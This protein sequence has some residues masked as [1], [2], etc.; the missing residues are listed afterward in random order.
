MSNIIND[1]SA[2][3]V[4]GLPTFYNISSSGIFVGGYS[5]SIYA[6]SGFPAY[7]PP[8]TAV[9]SY[10]DLQSNT[11]I[12]EQFPIGG[13]FGPSTIGITTGSLVNGDAIGQVTVTVV[14]IDFFPG[15]SPKKLPI[16][17]GEFLARFGAVNVGIDGISGVPNFEVSL[18]GS[19]ITN[20]DPNANYEPGF[21][22]GLGINPSTLPPHIVPQYD[23]NGALI[24][25]DYAS[26]FAAGT[27]IEMWDGSTKPIEEVN[28][29]D[30]VLSFD[31]TTGNTCAGRVV[32]TQ[33][34]DV[35]VVLDFFGTIVTPGHVYYCSGGR[36]AGKFVPL[37]D[38]LRDDGAIQTS[39]GEDVRATTGAVVGSP[40]D[41]MIQVVTGPVQ[42]DGTVCVTQS[43]QMRAGTRVLLEDGRDFSLSQMIEAADA[44]ITEDGLVC[45]R[46]EGTGTA[47]HWTFSTHLPNPEDFVLRKSGTDLYHIY[48][49]AE[50][51]AVGPQIAAPVQLDGGPQKPDPTGVVPNHLV[52]TEASKPQH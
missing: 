4:A 40:D 26:C 34:N 9:V 7:N 21:L 6:D 52:R 44:F 10:Y 15:G 17:L 51:E 22:E 2:G 33:K 45:S 18:I 47:F 3:A 30:L 8:A 20:I 41:Q 1:G 24:G 39:E 31:A 38:I 50:W 42:P 36:F 48:K 16:P 49:A 5:F 28:V 43:K 46:K 19:N 32:R 29:D 37:L 35:A 23:P 14:P 25:F 12:T 11:T 27:P 13:Q